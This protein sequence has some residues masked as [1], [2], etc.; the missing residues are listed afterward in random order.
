MFIKLVQNIRSI[1]FSKPIMTLHPKKKY[2][3]LELE[4]DIKIDFI[5][6][7]DNPKIEKPLKRKDTL[8]RKNII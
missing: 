5:H 2:V 6:Y 7:K 8:Y 1:D 3:V 4:K